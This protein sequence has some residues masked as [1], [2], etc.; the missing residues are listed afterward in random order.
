MAPPSQTPAPLN[1]RAVASWCLYDWANSA[2]NTIITTF[3]FSVYFARG[4]VGDPVEGTA[5]WSAAMTL[6]GVAIA[7]LSPLLGAIADRHGRRKPWMALFTGVTV[8]FS[9]AL[10]W[11]RP[12]PADALFALVCVV[13][14]TVAFE[15]A[16]VFYNA[17]LPAL[18]PARLLGR[19][20]GWGWGIGYFGGLACLVLALFGF[21]KAEAPLFGLFGL[22]WD[23]WGPQ[24][25]IRATALLVALWYGIFAL[26]Y[27]LWVPDAPSNG[28]SLIQATREGVATLVGTLRQAGRHRQTLR[29]L[30][31]SA[32]F[33]D[34]INTITAFGG[35]FAAG[36]FGMSFEEIVLFAIALNVVAGAGAIGFAWMDDR[37][38]AK[39]VILAALVGMT[40]F[41]L[42]LLLVTDKLWFWVLALGLG[43]FFGPAQAAGRSLMA[44]LSPPDM[45]G[46]MF[47][48]YG[49]TGRF[50]GFFGP[51]LFGL[52][53]EAFASQRA[54]MATVLAFFVIGFVLM[55]GVREPVA[56][57][58]NA[59]N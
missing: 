15:L 51:F 57:R 2:Y 12:D 26:P 48:L 53:T 46:E 11:V 24:A 35:L 37:A 1:R 8:A 49:L 32:F 36:S 52:A 22:S 30:I 21:V 58:Q 9:A 14:A 13:V 27:F 6:A 38:G 50:V 25:N 4:V 40:L 18:V 7:L 43:L 5:R 39:P 47:G 3:V 42:P 45:T 19:V 23:A 16:N 55:L 31:A 33:R 29:F 28:Q 54:G 41:G 34:G 20:S 56:P 10:W 44:R 17:S 59:A